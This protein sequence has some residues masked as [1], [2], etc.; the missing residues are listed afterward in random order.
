M[1]DNEPIIWFLSPTQELSKHDEVCS[2]LRRELHEA[3]LSLSEAR[4]S[5]AA[6]QRQE[7]ATRTTLEA[8]IRD[9]KQRIFNLEASH[10]IKPCS[11][12]CCL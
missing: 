2:R 8:E 1:S 4:S 6:T 11:E 10:L 5:L 7:K 12:A 9:L 3:N